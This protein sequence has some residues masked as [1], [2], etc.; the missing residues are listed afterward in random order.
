M[1]SFCAFRRHWLSSYFSGTDKPRERKN[2]RRKSKYGKNGQEKKFEGNNELIDRKEKTKKGGTI[3]HTPSTLLDPLLSSTR[4]FSRVFT[5]FKHL[6]LERL[7][8]PPD[9]GTRHLCPFSSSTLCPSPVFDSYTPSPL[10][11]FPRPPSCLVLV[12]LLVLGRFSALSHFELACRASSIIEKRGG[13]DR[14]REKK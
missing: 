6:H 5:F 13:Q 2:W 12:L 8:H 10:V 9:Q 4:L 11:C 3:S 1:V 7:C 14:K